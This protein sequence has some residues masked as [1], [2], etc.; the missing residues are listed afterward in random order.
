MVWVYV[1]KRKDEVFEKFKQWKAL[2]ETQSGK[3]VKRLR[4]NNRLEFCNQ[5]FEVWAL[6][7]GSGESIDLLVCWISADWLVSS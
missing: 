5:Q 7:L 6:K 2:V 3:K 4:T 1:L